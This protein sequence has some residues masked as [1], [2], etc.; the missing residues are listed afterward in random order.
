MSVAFNTLVL[1]TAY[2]NEVALL[3]LMAMD[4]SFASC[5]N[6]ASDHSAQLRLL[7]W[8][9]LVEFVHRIPLQ[10]MEPIKSAMYI[11]VSWTG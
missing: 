3:I 7:M 5:Q 6:K 11:L 2:K 1:C 8:L 4:A 9:S 10:L